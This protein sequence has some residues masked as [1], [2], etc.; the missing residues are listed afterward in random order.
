MRTL[1]RMWWSA[2]PSANAPELLQGRKV[3]PHT[4]SVICSFLANDSFSSRRSLGKHC[5]CEE[6]PCEPAWQSHFKSLRRITN[7][8]PTVAL[9]PRDDRFRRRGR[10]SVPRY[11]QREDVPL[12]ALSYRWLPRKN[13]ARVPGP[14]W[15]PMTAP[16]YPMTTSRT[17]YFSFT[18]A[19]RVSASCRQSPWQMNTVSF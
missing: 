6:A 2:K 14:E 10:I 18:M 13:S 9:L 16:V 3:V 4:T 5:H 15:E 17:P 7:E 1:G 11:A 12:S 8:I 19:A